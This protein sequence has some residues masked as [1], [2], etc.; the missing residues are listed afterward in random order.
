MLL[1]CFFPLHL[2]TVLR[3]NLHVKFPKIYLLTF[4]LFIQT[5]NLFQAFIR[6]CST[7]KLYS[8]VPGLFVNLNKRLLG[9]DV[10]VIN[11]GRTKE[12]RFLFGFRL[13][14]QS[15]QRLLSTSML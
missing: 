12:T 6:N 10:T 13:R 14:Y 8:S 5:S 7:I 11:R 4:Y 3:L 15:R 9:V 1:Y 2:A